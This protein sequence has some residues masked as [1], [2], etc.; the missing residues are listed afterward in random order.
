M[1]HS[2]FLFT[3]CYCA[4]FGPLAFS[5]MAWRNS[6]VMHSVEKMTSL[7][8]HLYPMI[9][10]HAIRFCIPRPLAQ[11]RYPALVQLDEL[12]SRTAFGFSIIMY[13]GWQTLYWVFVAHGKKD[14]IASGARINSYSTMTQGKG[15][16]A[17]VLSKTKPHRR[18]AWF[19]LV[20]FVY[21][22]VTMLPAP[23][24]FYRNKVASATFL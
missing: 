22:I 16:L 11:Q 24:L 17:G 6:Y 9:V 18:E 13:A 5:I 15:A 12:N 1:P 21:T 8:I 2:V 10:F 14:K 23:F 20:Q 4:A 3:V 7:F 19:M